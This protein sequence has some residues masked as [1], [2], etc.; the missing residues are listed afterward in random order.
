MFDSALELMGKSL[1]DPHPHVGKYLGPPQIEFPF[2]SLYLGRDS[3]HVVFLLL[4]SG[5]LIVFHT[6]CQNA[7][8]NSIS[9]N[10]HTH[11]FCTSTV[12]IAGIV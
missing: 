1:G 12:N 4:V 3:I 10:T 2:D 8:F 11:S 5:I 7:V 9:S 6:R